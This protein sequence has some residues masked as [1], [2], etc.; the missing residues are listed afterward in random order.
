M[1]KKVSNKIETNF[2]KNLKKEYEEKLNKAI[3]KEQKRLQNLN[4]EFLES[5]L[6]LLLKNQKFEKDFI[7]ILEENKNDKIKKIYEKLKAEYS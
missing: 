1:V 2:I 4:Q 3:E 5:L 7:N 6:E